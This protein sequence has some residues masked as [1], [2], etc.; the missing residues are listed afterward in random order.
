[1]DDQRCAVKKLLLAI[2]LLLF[3][4]GVAILLDDADT[5]Y[6]Y[7]VHSNEVASITEEGYIMNWPTGETP[8]FAQVSIPSWVVIF[9][10]LGG[11]LYAL[12]F[13]VGKPYRGL[14]WR[15]AE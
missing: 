6:R 7:G 11:G 4:V 2:S 10:L 12:R 13:C 8:W 1:L 15:G 9:W 14:L 5:F 3:G